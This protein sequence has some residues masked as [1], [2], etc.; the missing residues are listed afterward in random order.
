MTTQARR[1]SREQALAKLVARFGKGECYRGI[2]ATAETLKQGP[3]LLAN[4]TLE[5]DGL[6]LCLD[7]LKRVDGAS[8]LGGHRY[9]PV[10][11]VQASSH[12]GRF[13][14]LAT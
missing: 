13:G 14:H 12:G 11:H 9:L 2:A 10:L 8:E 5:D 7:A 6:S 4:V 1:A 3:P